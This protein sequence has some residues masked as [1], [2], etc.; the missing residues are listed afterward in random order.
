LPQVRFRPYMSPGDTEA[1]LA[2]HEQKALKGGAHTRIK[3]ALQIVAQ[4]R[5]CRVRPRRAGALDSC[6]RH[7]RQCARDLQSDRKRA[8]KVSW[9]AASAGEGK[10][11]R[12]VALFFFNYNTVEAFFLACAILVNLAG[13]MFQSDYLSTG[14]RGSASIETT[15]TTW[16]TMIIVIFSICYFFVIVFVELAQAFAFN[17]CARCA[18]RQQAKLA[19]KAAR[20]A[21]VKDAGDDVQYDPAA[22]ALDSASTSVAMNPMFQKKG[23][24]EGPAAGGVPVVCAALCVRMCVLRVRAQVTVCVCVCV[25]K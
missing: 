10:R 23:V 3:F 15:G 22:A 7:R 4:V 12:Q 19:A 24:T 5:A 20:Q 25:H 9:G 11:G 18:K 21:A 17:P 6:M 8:H 1:V 14:T 16:G 13:V 2:T